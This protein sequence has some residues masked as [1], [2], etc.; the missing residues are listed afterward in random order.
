MPMERF[1]G[2]VARWDLRGRS[3]LGNLARGNLHDKAGKGKQSGR[4]GGQNKRPGRIGNRR[5]ATGAMKAI[6]FS[7]FLLL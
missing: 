5:A 4:G 7:P 6:R 2:A 3:L 1:G